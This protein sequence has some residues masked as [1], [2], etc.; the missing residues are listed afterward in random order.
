L[1]ANETGVARI[2]SDEHGERSVVV[3]GQRF[4]PSQFADLLSCFEGFDLYWQVR[5]TSDEPPEWL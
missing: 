5:N 2:E 3:D 1:Y 4:S